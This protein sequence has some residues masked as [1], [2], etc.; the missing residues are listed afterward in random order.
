MFWTNIIQKVSTKT[1]PHK[2]STKKRPQKVVQKS[3]HQKC[4]QE[5]YTKNVH[6]KCPQKVSTKVSTRS[7][8]KKLT[9]KCP[10]IVSTKSVNNS[11][12]E[13]WGEGRDWGRRVRGDHWE[14]CELIMLSQGQ[15]YAS[16]QL[17]WWR[18]QTHTHRQKDIATLRLNWPS[19]PIQWKK[20]C[21]ISIFFHQERLYTY[22]TSIFWKAKFI[23]NQD[24]QR[25]IK[26]FLNS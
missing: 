4:P 8:K 2:A 3:V 24:C 12:G 19:G 1:C 7:V 13:G 20:I 5:V 14:A 6:K 15:W 10:Q 23:R 9:K 25:Y 21:V 17:H 11:V 16:K 22:Q 18:K 26:V